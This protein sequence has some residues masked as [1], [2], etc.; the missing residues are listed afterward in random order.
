MHPVVLAKEPIVSTLLL[1]VA[2]CSGTQTIHLTTSEPAE[3]WKLDSQTRLCERAP[4][5]YSYERQGCGFP[6]IMATNK[7]GF[8]ARTPD[9]RVARVI[10]RDYCDV[11]NEWFIR[12]EPKV[13]P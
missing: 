4:C 6:R 9:G 11:D 8:E 3:I 1:L 7:I 2:A 10:A 5:D 12:I 13:K